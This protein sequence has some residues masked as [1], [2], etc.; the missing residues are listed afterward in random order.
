MT[1]ATALANRIE[2]AVRLGFVSRDPNDKDRFDVDDL[3]EFEEQAMIVAALRA[4]AQPAVTTGAE[5]IGECKPFSG[6][7]CRRN[8]PDQSACIRYGGIMKCLE[9]LR[10]SLP[11]PKTA[12][13]EPM[14]WRCD[15]TG[16]LIGT[17]TVMIGMPECQCQGH[18]AS[19][20]SQQVPV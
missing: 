3:I 20:L 9:D 4:T 2:K 14:D 10:A 1:D 8:Y 18:R 15:V 5:P 16:N 17:D 11:Q 19:R 12:P 13:G 7:L 6:M